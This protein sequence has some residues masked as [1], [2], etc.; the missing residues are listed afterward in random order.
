MKAVVMNKSESKYYNTACLM[1]EA[2]L[3][4][5]EKKNY[6]Y[7]TVKEICEKAGVNRS[8]FYLHYETTDDLLSETISY[9]SGKRDSKFKK[10]I[11][12]R[13]IE[14]SSLEELNLVTPE[15]LL[16]YLEFVRENKKVYLAAATQPYVFRT[17]ESF[18]KL[19]NEIFDPILAKFNIPEKD[20]EYKTAFYLNGIFSVIMAWIKNDCADDTEYISGL[21]TECLNA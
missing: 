8:T 21:I 16:P 17:N 9:I 19:Y 6:E 15:Y 14:S 2:L 5:L 1:D 20:R 13:Y 18:R 3:S 7:I 12:L 11:D 10:S 4:L